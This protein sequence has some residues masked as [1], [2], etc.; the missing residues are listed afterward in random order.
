ME[1]DQATQ[2]AEQAAAA[3]V[4]TQDVAALNTEEVKAIEAVNLPV[5]DPTALAQKPTEQEPE[6][7]TT[8]DQASAIE[9]PVYAGPAPAAPYHL[10]DNE[11]GAINQIASHLGKPHAEAIEAIEAVDVSMRDPLVAVYKQEML[12]WLNA[13]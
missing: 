3:A 6:Q 9:E 11:H 7:A 4:T 1:N 8:T 12:D 5:I 13:H 2:A 10:I